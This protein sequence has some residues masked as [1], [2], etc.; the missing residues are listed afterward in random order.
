MLLA[1]CSRAVSSRIACW[2][3][4]TLPHS[5]LVTKSTRRTVYASIGAAI[6]S[7]FTR[8]ATITGDSC[9]GRLISTS[10]T[11]AASRSSG[12]RSGC[13]DGTF[14]T[15][16]VTVASRVGTGCA[17]FLIAAA[18]AGYKISWVRLHTILTL[19]MYVVSTGRAFVARH[20][21]SLVL[22]GTRC[23]VY[24]RCRRAG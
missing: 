3:L 6:E 22:D 9:L 18:L 16:C 1:E 21:A 2:C 17:T 7:K 8:Q 4:V 19:A 20:L 13:A 14:C 24:A 5:C 15:I 23:T 11:G 12:I 10:D